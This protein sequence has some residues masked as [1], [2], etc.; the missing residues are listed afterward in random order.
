MPQAKSGAKTK[1][2]P[3]PAPVPAFGVVAP[4]RRKGHGARN[5]ISEEYANAL[6]DALD[7]AEPKEWV[8]GPDTFD[9]KG[10]AVA[11]ATRHRRALTD[12]KLVDAM[13]DVQSRVWE[14]SEGEFR[15]AL[16]LRVA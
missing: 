13:N 16:R 5:V 2:T 15:F 3:A 10:K 8:G 14:S 6:A 11:A 1:D 9:T 4:P 12:Y 7:N